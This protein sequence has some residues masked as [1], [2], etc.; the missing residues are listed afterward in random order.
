VA[1]SNGAGA[2]GGGGGAAQGSADFLRA[3]SLFTPD[4]VFQPNAAISG[5]AGGGGGAVED[6][7]GASETGNAAVT[8][9]TGTRRL[10]G[11]DDG[12]GGG[13]SGGGSVWI[14]ARSILVGSTGQIDVRGGAGG[15]TFGPADH[16]ISDPDNDVAG[17]EYV[18]GVVNPNAAGTGQGGGGGGGSGGAILLQGRDAVTISAGA[19]LTA[20][21]GAGGTSATASGGAGAVGRIGI[22][23]FQATTDFGTNGTVTLGGTVTP[24]AGVSGAVW[25]P[26]IDETSQGVAKWVDL[27]GTNTAFQIP[28]WTDNVAT[29]TGAPNNLT[30]GADFDLVVELQGATGL[31]A[32]PDPTTATALTAW[33]VHSS[34]ATLNG[35]QYVR[36]RARFRVRRTGAL[37]PLIH[38]MPTIF[39]LTV[40]FQKI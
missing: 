9:I 16:L 22:M 17:D 12:A 36:W 11:G 8:V 30:Q 21:G 5:G 28:F 29:L 27:L 34:F 31:N 10:A 24:A 6:D 40:P 15:N 25:Q 39:D 19:V 37:D 14:L 18:A 7:N 32:L 20:A 35:M 3:L 1:G 2:G 33:T 38:P 26:T 13:G 23:A 4:R